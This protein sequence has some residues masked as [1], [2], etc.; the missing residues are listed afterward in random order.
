MLMV[1][2]CADAAVDSNT[3]PSAVSNSCP[4]TAVTAATPAAF[5]SPRTPARVLL[6]VALAPYVASNARNVA[7]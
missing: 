3:K 5:P 6:V 2:V 1:L 4:P 7:R